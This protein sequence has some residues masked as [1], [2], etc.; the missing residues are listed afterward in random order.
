MSI[1]IALTEITAL[2]FVTG[3]ELDVFWVV[4]P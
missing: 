4:T 2:K 3:I 1:D